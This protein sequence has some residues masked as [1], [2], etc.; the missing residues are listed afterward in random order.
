MVRPTREVLTVRKANSRREPH[1]EE[2]QYHVTLVSGSF[3]LAPVN[4][5]LRNLLAAQH[6]QSFALPATGNGH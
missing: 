4:Q 6:A 5:T 1:S 3:L 2:G